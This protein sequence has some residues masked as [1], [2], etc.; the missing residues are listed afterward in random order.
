M[1]SVWD[2]AEYWVFGA[3]FTVVFAK[4][5]DLMF[6]EPPRYLGGSLLTVLGLVGLLFTIPWTRDKTL[7]ALDILYAQFGIPYPLM[8]LVAVS[9]LGAIVFGGGWLLLRSRSQ[10]SNTG[11]SAVER[12]STDPDLY[13]TMAT[14]IQPK[15]TETL[16]V[17]NVTV[18]NRGGSPSITTNWQLGWTC[19]AKKGLMLN[20]PIYPITEDDLALQG[21]GIMEGSTKSGL[22]PGGEAHYKLIYTLPCSTEERRENEVRLELTFYDVRNRPFTIGDSEASAQV[23]EKIGGKGGH[24]KVEGSGVAI[25]GPGGHAG[26]YGSGGAGGNAEVQG[27]GIS[28]GGE[29][30]SAGDDEVWRPPARSGYEVYKERMGQTPDPFIRQYG[31]GGEVP[32]YAAKF[33]V[34]EKLRADYFRA[35]SEPPQNAFENIHAV[36]LDYL[37][38]ALGAMNEKWRVRIVQ[39]PNGQY[40][41]FVPKKAGQ[42]NE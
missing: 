7:A 11:I 3:I 19:G 28:V 14:S 15:G 6:S 34:I 36:P 24:A 33:Q 27:S 5:L 39:E 10:V 20:A 21:M 26:K 16:V 37:N 18:R 29:G 8:S 17:L 32:G 13:G 23:P 30:G 25:G 42:S 38:G 41:F 35:H 9:L 4:G 22:P 12:S 40:E 2:T 31:R 1:S